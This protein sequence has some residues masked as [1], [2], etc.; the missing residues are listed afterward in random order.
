MGELNIKLFK[1]LRT[2]FLRMRHPQ[3]FRMKQVAIKTDC[4]AA[5]CMIG[6][7][8][9]LEGYKMR[10]RKDGPKYTGTDAARSDYDFIDPRT[11][12]AVYDPAEVAKEL[13]GLD[14]WS[15][16]DN[17]FT[18]YNLKTPQQAARRI[19]QIIETGKVYAEK[20][21]QG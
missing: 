15:N 11:G 13:L 3:H 5:M 4:G 8:L 21:E 1:R 17:L 6:H 2:R 9:T 16:E 10:L 12:K 18:E 14:S 19:Q 7:V 20:G